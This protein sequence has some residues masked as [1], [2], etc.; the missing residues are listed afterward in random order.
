MPLWFFH[1][2]FLI[3]KIVFLPFLN[4][5]REYLQSLVIPCITLIIN[6]SEGA[7]E[8]NII[9]NDN[10]GNNVAIDENANILDVN[11][12]PIE[13]LYG[14]GDMVVGSIFGEPPH[15]AGGNVYGSM[16]TGMLAGDSAAAYV[17]GEI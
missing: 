10:Q 8:P 7:G 14:G 16:P 3:K 13:G 17:K 11:N 9:N 4:E 5:I 2:F 6:N 12:Y 15:N 1:S